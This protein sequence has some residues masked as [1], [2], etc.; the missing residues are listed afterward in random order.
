[1][2]NAKRKALYLFLT[3]LLGILLLLMFHRSL[4]V[5]YDILGGFFPTNPFFDVRSEVI[6]TLDF[7]TMIVAM[8]L[9]G[10]Y[11]VWLGLDWYKMIY[12]ERESREWFHGFLPHHWRGYHAR[13]YKTQKNS[14]PEFEKLDAMSSPKRI[15]VKGPVA[16]SRRVESFASFKTTPAN[17]AWSFDD[18][19][20]PSETA[21]T[22]RKAVAKKRVVKKKVAK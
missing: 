3:S 5:I 12:E 2:T 9:G 10:W 1:M 20:A 16:A 11:G 6:F 14:E 18:V 15:V 13:K 19:A 22:K 7:F 4:F 21:K 8:F 17:T